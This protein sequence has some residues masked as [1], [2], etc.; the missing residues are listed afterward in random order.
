MPRE[1]VASWFVAAVGERFGEEAILA[2][3]GRGRT[4]S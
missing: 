3:G 4:M 2:G 1:E